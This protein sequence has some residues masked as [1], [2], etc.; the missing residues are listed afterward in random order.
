MAAVR[1]R[2]NF[3]G[4]WLSDNGA[5][6]VTERAEAEKVSKSEMLRRMIAYAVWKMPR[7]WKP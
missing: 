5:R 2:P 7:G 4:V 1:K 6:T 3:M